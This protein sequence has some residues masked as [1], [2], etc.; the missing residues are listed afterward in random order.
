MA[1]T[2]APRRNSTT[3]NSAEPAVIRN[4]ADAI[5]ENASDRC[6]LWYNPSR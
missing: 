4:E 3:K 5:K 6:S 1:V 2:T